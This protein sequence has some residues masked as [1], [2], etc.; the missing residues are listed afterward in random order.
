MILYKTITMSL[1]NSDLEALDAFVLAMQD[2]GIE[3]S[4]SQA[5]RAAIGIL[6]SLDY[7]Q[8]SRLLRERATEDERVGKP[9]R[10]T[11]SRGGYPKK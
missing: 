2:Q 3:T 4:R 10:L 5:I 1:Y 8:A 6:V 9:R 11:K 7:M